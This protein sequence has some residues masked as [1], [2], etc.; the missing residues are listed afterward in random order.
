MNRRDMMIGSAKV[1]LGAGLLNLSESQNAVAAKAGA[2]KIRV[3]A[4]CSTYHYLSHAYHIVG[5]FLDGFPLYDGDDTFHEPSDS[6]EIS[7]I[8]IEQMPEATD[9]GRGVAKRHGIPLYDSIEKAL[10]CGGDRL[11]VDA[12]LIIAE[13]GKYP[14]NEKYQTL[15][16]RYEYFSEVVRV[17]QKSGRSVPVFNDKHLSYDRVK[18][19]Q[20]VRWSRDLNFP[21]MAGSSLPVT[22]RRP[23]LEIPLKSQIEDVAVLSRGEIEIFGFHAL[24]TLQTFMER[25]DLKGNPQGVKAVTCLI[26][27]AVWEAEK[28]GRWS[29]E[30]LMQAARR[31]FSRNVGSIQQCCSEFNPPPNRPTFLRTPIFFEVEYADGLIGKIVVANGYVD[32]TSIAVK[33]AGGTNRVVS[34][35]VYLPAPPGASFFNPLVLRIEDFYRSG[36]APYPVER[37][38]LTG[39]IL[40]ALLESRLQNSKRIETPDLAS[41]DYAAP[42]DSGYIRT[43]WPAN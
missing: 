20:M 42:A 2:R 1:G 30:L 10:C 29:M 5:R 15:Y 4:L 3:A 9:L 31:S 36:K 7:S 18:A 13:H 40:D 39:G 37:T 19:A 23:D 34:T 14:I 11:D 32:D 25:R 17:F 22:W 41:I 26:G 38:Q 21:L 33:L 8:Y 24:E 27:D 12:V 28:Q 35:N 16:P 43:P 6:F